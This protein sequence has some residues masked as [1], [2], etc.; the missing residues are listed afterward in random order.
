MSGCQPE[1]NDTKRDRAEQTPSQ[2]DTAEGSKTWVLLVCEKNLG[3]N[4]LSGSV[5]PGLVLLF[6]SET[7]DQHLDMRANVRGLNW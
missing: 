4:P 6:A 2:Y 1:A 3:L 7:L 5:T